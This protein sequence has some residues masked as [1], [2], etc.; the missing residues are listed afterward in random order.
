MRSSRLFMR[1]VTYVDFVRA[2][3]ILVLIATSPLETRA[4]SRAVSTE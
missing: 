1:T 3:V 4:V 2:R